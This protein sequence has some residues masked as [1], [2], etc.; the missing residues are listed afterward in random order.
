M[1]TYVPYPVDVEIPTDGI[2]INLHPNGIYYL[3]YLFLIIRL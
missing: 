1:S 3:F 2:I